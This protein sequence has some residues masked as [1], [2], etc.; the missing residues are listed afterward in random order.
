MRA[1][2]YQVQQHKASIIEYGSKRRICVQFP[3]VK[4]MS[5]EQDK[6]I[7]KAIKLY[8]AKKITA[9]ECRRRLQ[10]IFNEPTLEDFFKQ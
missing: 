5:S 6:R 7:R 8:Y 10:D 9:E 3:P 4:T 2:A 1:E